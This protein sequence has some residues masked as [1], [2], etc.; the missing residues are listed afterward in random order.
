MGQ[1]LPTIVRPFAVVISESLTTI[2]IRLPAGSYLFHQG[3]SCN[4]LYILQTG[5]ADLLLESEFA[6]KQL[7]QRSA[8]AV[9][10]LSECISGEVRCSS[11]RLVQDCTLQFAPA[12]AVRELLQNN[13]LVCIQAAAVISEEIGCSLDLI[14]RFHPP[15]SSGCK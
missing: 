8:P 13:P 11:A 2:P 3:D 7:S 9:I 5:R 4:G 14:K 15:R 1:F 6:T 12:E 10:G